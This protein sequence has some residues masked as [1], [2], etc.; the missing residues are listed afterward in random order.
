[1]QILNMNKLKNIK[2]IIWDW[3]GTL[4]NDADYCVDCMNI[5][6]GKRNIPL[7]NIDQY[8][9]H[10]TFPVKDYYEAIGFDFEKEDFEVPAMEFINKY[11]ENLNKASL[12]VCVFEILDYFKNLGYKQL[13][14]SAMEHENLIKSLTDKGIINY[15]EEIKG[16]DDHYAISKLEMGKSL[17]QQLNID[18]E[19]TVMIGDTTHDLEVATGLGI[20]CI[21]VSGGHQSK[22]RLLAATSNVILKLGEITKYIQ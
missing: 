19:T 13:V 10:F 7:I 18:S 9:T 21:L 22:E 1:M 12:H 14:L 16:I 8:R 2:T 20:D 6:L 11:Y 5:V 4:L 17:M 3:N 15:F